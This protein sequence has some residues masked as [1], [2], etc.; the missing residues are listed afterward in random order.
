[1]L[2]ESVA[3]TRKEITV[4][5]GLTVQEALRKAVLEIAEANKE[6]DDTENKTPL[7]TRNKPDLNKV[8]EA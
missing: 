6:S 5:E 1:M 7:E 3:H 4:K 8:E 2:H